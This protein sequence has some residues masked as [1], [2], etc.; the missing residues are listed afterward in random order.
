MFSVTAPA[1]RAASM[2]GSNFVAAVVMAFCSVAGAVYD[3]P[4]AL[5]TP[6]YSIAISDG[7][8]EATR[9]E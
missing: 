7:T 9:L 3:S 6:A 4:A 2:D 5:S 8:P 1:L